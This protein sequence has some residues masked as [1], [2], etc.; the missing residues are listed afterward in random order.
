MPNAEYS[1]MSEKRKATSSF[2]APRINS[3]QATRISRVLANEEQQQ[4]LELQLVSKSWSA[5]KR[6]K[7]ADDESE[8]KCESEK[9]ELK[10]LPE[11][12]EAERERC[13]RTIIFHLLA[14][15]F[16]CGQ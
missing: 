13:E 2:C 9:L 5:S 16:A 12:I 7:E 1:S 10:L 4:Q 6:R 14:G 11:Q 8:N 3:I 15:P